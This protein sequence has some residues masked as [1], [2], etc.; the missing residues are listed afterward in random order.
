[1]R[2]AI[3]R[4]RPDIVN[5]HDLQGIGYNLLREIGRQRLPC[6]QTL[7]DL[8]FLCMNMNMFKDGEA[9]RVGTFPA[10]SRAS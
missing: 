5:T 4:F 8:G 9:A 2:E 10:R 7:H 1:M 6:V 3:E